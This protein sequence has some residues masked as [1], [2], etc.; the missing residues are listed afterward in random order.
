MSN[1][2]N[3]RGRRLSYAPYRAPCSKGI[4]RVNELKSV[5][6]G[7]RSAGRGKTGG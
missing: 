4:E 7:S 6:V 2:Y 5:E 1:N 3:R